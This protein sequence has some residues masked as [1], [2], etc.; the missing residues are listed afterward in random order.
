MPVKILGKT[1]ENH[2]SAVQAL[3]KSKPDISDPDAYVATVERQE[4]GAK[5][6][7]RFAVLQKEVKLEEGKDE[8]VL[9]LKGQERPPFKSK[10]TGNEESSSKQQTKTKEDPVKIRAKTAKIFQKIAGVGHDNATR[11]ATD[12]EQKQLE[13]IKKKKESQKDYQP[14]RYE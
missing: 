1:Y 3:K 8:D 14:S 13:S 4:K 9:K 12:D 5:L 6:K 2:D 7:N 10:G 11:G